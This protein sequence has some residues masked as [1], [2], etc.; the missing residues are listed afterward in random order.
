MIEREHSQHG[1]E[2]DHFELDTERE[3]YGQN[4]EDEKG[5]SQ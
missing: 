4:D 2:C 3:G 1:P 5:E